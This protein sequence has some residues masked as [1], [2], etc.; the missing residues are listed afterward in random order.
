MPDISRPYSSRE[1]DESR[2]MRE[3]AEQVYNLPLSRE[4]MAALAH[5]LHAA[6]T[7][8]DN[9]RPLPR[10]MRRAANHVVKA[11]RETR[12]ASERA[13]SANQPRQR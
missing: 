4:L 12:L 1:A 3:T 11:V 5:T 6:A 8:L 9:G 10:E 7:E 13:S 2:Q